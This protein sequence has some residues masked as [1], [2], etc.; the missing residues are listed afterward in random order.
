MTPLYILILL[1]RAFSVNTFKLW[2]HLDIIKVTRIF[3]SDFYP[4]LYLL[5]STLFLF[6]IISAVNSS[7]KL[8][9]NKII[10]ITIRKSSHMIVSGRAR[11]NL[12]PINRTYPL[13]L[14]CYIYTFSFI[15]N[16]QK[17]FSLFLC[18]TQI[19][20]N[21]KLFHNGLYRWMKKL[22]YFSLYFFSIFHPIHLILMWVTY[23]WIIFLLSII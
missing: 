7:V 2:H 18:Y 15:Q 19:F 20:Y 23:L 16:L 21:S 9:F 8:L 3:S 6:Y 1:R 22:M 17:F 11:L 5:F 4:F 10:F 13:Y 12:C 14:I